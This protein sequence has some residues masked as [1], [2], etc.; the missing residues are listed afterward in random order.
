MAENGDE[1][2]AALEAKI[3]HQI[4]VWSLYYSTVETGSLRG[5]LGPQNKYRKNIYFRS[6]TDPLSNIWLVFDSWN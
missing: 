3:C 2:V 6:Y 5:D 4:E 1:K